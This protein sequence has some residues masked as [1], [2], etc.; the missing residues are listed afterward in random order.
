MTSHVERDPGLQRERSQLAWTRTGLTLCA[1]VVL[2]LKLHILSTLGI[3]TTLCL[4]WFALRMGVRR[5]HLIAIQLSVVG[6]TELLRKVAL[7]LF[8]ISMGVVAFLSFIIPLI[9]QPA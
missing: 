7:S 6:R 9:R 5:K 1:A 2:L 4:A 8:V 3:I